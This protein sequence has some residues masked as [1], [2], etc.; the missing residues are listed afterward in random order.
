MADVGGRGSWRASS[1]ILW[2]CCCGPPPRWPRSSGSRRWRSPSSSSS[3]STRLFAFVQEVQAERAVEALAEY[4]PPQANVLRDGE[5]QIID[6]ARV[7]PGDLLLVEEGDR[8]SADARLLEG[9]IE[10]DLS[11][12]TGESMPAFRSAELLDSSVPLLQARDLV[13]SGTTCTEGEARAVVFATGMH[14]EL[15]RI[16]ALSERVEQEESPL[17]HQVRRVAWLIALIAVV[18]GIAFI[19]T[20]HARGRALADQWRGLRRRPA[21]GQRPGGAAAGDHAGPGGRRS[22]ARAPGS[23]GQAPERR[24]DAGL[25]Q[26]HLHRQDRDAHR[27]PHARDHR[28][29]ARRGPRTARE[30]GGAGSGR[31]R[32]TPGAGRGARGVDERMQQRRDRGRRDHDRRPDRGGDASRR[33]EPRCRCQRRGSRTPSAPP[34]SLRPGTQADVDRGSS[35]TASCGSMP[36]ALPKRCSPAAQPW[37]RVRRRRR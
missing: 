12:L 34:V 15:G 19:P 26:R 36:R 9:A 14:T 24:R 27:E 16:A 21:G 22:R 5:R 35:A 23:R 28:L 3:S 6:A 13:F 1:R 20:R 37:P 33:T 17:E 7:V 8:V 2:R 25:H 30:R 29:D 4:L 10:V 32:R 18:T 31:T 11:T